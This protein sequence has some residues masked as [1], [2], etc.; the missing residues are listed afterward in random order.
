MLLVP[1]VG[2]ELLRVTREGRGYRPWG[3]LALV[4]PVVV[5]F[6]AWNRAEPELQTLV[7]RFFLNVDS[8][9]PLVSTENLAWLWVSFA[10]EGTGLGTATG[11]VV[12]LFALGVWAALR[13]G[14]GN[15]GAARTLVLFVLCAVAALLLHRYKL[16]R[17]VFV[18]VPF[19]YLVALVPVSRAAVAAAERGRAGLFGG[20]LVALGALAAVAHTTRGAVAPAQFTECRHLGHALD[21]VTEVALRSDRV[22]VA[23]AHRAMNRHLIELWTRLAGSNAEVVFEEAYPP[24]CS[25]P[26]DEVPGYCSPIV[27]RRYLLSDAEVA[28][29][30]VVSVSPL[31]TRSGAG[32]RGRVE[33]SVLVARQVGELALGV[34]HTESMRVDVRDEKVSVIVYEPAR[35]TAKD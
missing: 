21:I 9:I 12:G 31:G 27:T 1:L 26:P 11:L 6:M 4:A 32:A 33:W 30:S 19:V 15:G 5:G 23:G 34:G 18:I 25:A 13:S 14:G 20:L 10:A 16:G 17:N 3:A 24:A 35:V 22:V 2:M 29:T 7:Q 8:G 28:R